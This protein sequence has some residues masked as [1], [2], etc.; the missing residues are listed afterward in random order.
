MNAKKSFKDS[1]SNPAMQFISITE[2]EH[3]QKEA[4]EEVTPLKEVNLKE[5]MNENYKINYKYVEKR[6]KRVQMLMQP[7]L[8][9]KVKNRATQN[10]R[11]VNDELH[12]IIE[13]TIK[14]E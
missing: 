8:Y 2:E 13:A 9:E 4:I 11:S 3:E 5:E 12:L 10:G 14:G 1:I 6:N 7:S